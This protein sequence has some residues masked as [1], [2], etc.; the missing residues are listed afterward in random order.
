MSFEFGE[1]S[2]KL[3]IGVDMRLIEIAEYALSISLIDFGIPNS[4]GVRLVIEQQRLFALG[5]SKADGVNRRSRHQDGL[6]LDVF[7]YVDG[8][9]SWKKAELAMVAAAMLQA[10]SNL[11]HSLYWGGLWKSE[12][13][14]CYGWDM[15]HFELTD[16]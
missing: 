1:K 13:D 15:G 10:A 3:M 6:A 12:D 16:E 5:V 9:A 11:G 7:A 2:K 14:S 4:G 8:Q